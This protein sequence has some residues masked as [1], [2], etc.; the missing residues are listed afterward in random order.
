MWKG[1]LQRRISEL[2]AGKVVFYVLSKHGA[3]PSGVGRY[4]WACFQNA[5]ETTGESRWVMWSF[6]QQW[7]SYCLL[8]FVAMCVFFYRMSSGQLV[9]VS[10]FAPGPTMDSI[11]W[12]TATLC[13]S[14]TQIVTGEIKWQSAT[15]QHKR[16]QLLAFK[17]T[18]EHKVWRVVHKCFWGNCADK[19]WHLQT[20]PTEWFLC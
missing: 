4:G 14:K 1:E 16:F 17:S 6:A 13:S 11:C 15:F 5:N 8:G 10:P 20:S 9:L 2:V 7:E 12:E 19:C 3:I 18:C